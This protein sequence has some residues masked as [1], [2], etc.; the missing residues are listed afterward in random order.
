MSKFKL[1]QK[2]TFDDLEG[3]KGCYVVLSE[4]PIGVLTAFK[5]GISKLEDNDQIADRA[6]EFI[7][8]CFVEGKGF[9]GTEI[10]DITKE[11]I[12]DLPFTIQ[13]RLKDFLIIGQKPSTKKSKDIAS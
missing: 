2:V 7:S 3:W 4:P 8:E 11:D 9:S 6:I 12:K 1:L 10:I 5:G 13:N